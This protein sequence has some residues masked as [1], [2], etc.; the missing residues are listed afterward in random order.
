MEKNTTKKKRNLLIYESRC[1]NLCW[2]IGV[3]CI[4]QAS[5]AAG[6]QN[7][8]KGPRQTI[9][10]LGINFIHSTQMRIHNNTLCHSRTFTASDHQSE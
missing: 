2:T 5:N 1:H 10:K 3:S 9:T 7:N 8:N 6:Y 4:G